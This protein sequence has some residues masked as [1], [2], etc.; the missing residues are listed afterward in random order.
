MVEWREWQEWWNGKKNGRTAE[1]Q[2]GGMA[3]AMVEWREW[4]EWRNGKKNGRMAEW[5][6][7]D[8]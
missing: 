2:N 3:D 5:K 1:C 7:M 8:T 4:R 6:K